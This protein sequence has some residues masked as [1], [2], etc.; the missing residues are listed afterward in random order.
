MEFSAEFNVD[1]KQNT[2]FSLITYAR[3]DY[4]CIKEAGSYLEQMIQYWKMWM[5]CNKSRVSASAI[6]RQPS[7]RASLCL[8][9]P[10]MAVHWHISQIPALSRALPAA[11]DGTASEKSIVYF[12]CDI[13]MQYLMLLFTSLHICH[14]AVDSTWRMIR[15]PRNNESCQCVVP[16]FFCK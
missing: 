14:K 4:E 3:I 11:D 8:S 10:S 15:L 7:E 2:F 12:P 1:W 16:T 13:S 6:S 5:A 9:A